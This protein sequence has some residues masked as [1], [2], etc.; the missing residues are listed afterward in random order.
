MDGCREQTL[1]WWLQRWTTTLR[2]VP[3][4]IQVATHSGQTSVL[5]LWRHTATSRVVQGAKKILGRQRTASLKVVTKKVPQHAVN[6]LQSEGYKD[7]QQ[8]WGSCWGN[9][10]SRHTMDRLRSV[11]CEDIRHAKSRARHE[12]ESW[13]TTADYS[14][15]CPQDN[16]S[17]QRIDFGLRVVK[18]DGNAES[19]AGVKISPKCMMQA[20]PADITKING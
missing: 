16:S 10:K 5:G 13:Y 20:T 1:V 3:D 12:R 2:V 9:L 4:K 19:R 14:D 8:Y 18:T 7:R 15:G 6:R 17:T 11:G